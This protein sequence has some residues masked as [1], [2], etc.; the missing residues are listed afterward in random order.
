MEAV[1]IA[2]VHIN[3]E[4]S[5][6]KV[7]NVHIK[8]GKTIYFKAFAEGLFYTNINDPTMITYNINVSF[9][10]YSYLSTIEKNSEF[11]LI[12]QLKER[13]ESESYR[14]ISSGWPIDVV[15][16]DRIF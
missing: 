8:D 4:T 12:I 13:I 14:N 7:I 16:S 3:M 11:L 1:N 15:R 6:E 9:N 5:K 10:T 2:G